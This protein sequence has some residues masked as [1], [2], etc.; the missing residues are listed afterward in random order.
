MPRLSR[1]E[2]IEK[3]AEKIPTSGKWT[4]D[5]EELM[6]YAVNAFGDIPWLCKRIRELEADR[7]T[8]C[9][10]DSELYRRLKKAEGLLTIALP[11][12]EAECRRTTPSCEL[13]DSIR[14]F[15]SEVPND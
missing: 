14:A 15:L 1:L 3:R 5:R 9:A 2:E 10:E 6:E 12:H 13:V 8:L 11:V 4:I 7:R